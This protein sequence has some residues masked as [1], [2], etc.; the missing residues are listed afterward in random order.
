MLC[1]EVGVVRQ[2]VGTALNVGRRGGG[3]SQDER[4]NPVIPSSNISQQLTQLNVIQ[5]DMPLLWLKH[6][7]TCSSIKRLR[8]DHAGNIRAR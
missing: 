6:H 4:N 7:E 3:T 5:L 1:R 8:I 2:F